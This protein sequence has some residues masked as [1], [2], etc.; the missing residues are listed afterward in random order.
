MA[1]VTFASASGSPG[2]TTTCVGLALSWPR[3]VVLVEA[4]PTGGSSILAG[5]FGGTRQAGGLVDLVLAQRSGLL[6]DTLPRLLVDVYGSQAS[7]L[8]GSRSHEHAAG[9]TQVWEP[10]L[11]VLRDIAAS[12][13]DVIVDAGRLGLTG[14]PQPLVSGSDVT[15]LVTRSS[16]PVLAAARSWAA[17]LADEV[18][19]GH[20][21]QMLVVGPGQPYAASEVA[22]VLRLPVAGTLPWDPARAA[23]FSTGAPKPAT[24]IGGPAAA[25]RRFDASPFGSSLLTLGDRVRAAAAG[26]MRD[27]P[28]RSLLAARIQEARR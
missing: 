25:A 15:V 12:G 23:V 7:V 8:L 16:L 2:V 14:W 22:R 19:P 20:A 18:L 3:P 13:Q 10:L 24:R 26:V 4:D 5:F 27:S 9:L 1:L 6:A 17:S 28:V 11:A 21:V